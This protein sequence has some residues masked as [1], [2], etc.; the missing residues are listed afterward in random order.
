VKVASKKATIELCKR[1]EALDYRDNV[2]AK[3]MQKFYI[4]LGIAEPKRVAPVTKRSAVK[5]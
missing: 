4:A 3:E 5:R 2:V 1:S